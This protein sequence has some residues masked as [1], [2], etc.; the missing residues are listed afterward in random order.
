VPPAVADPL[1]PPPVFAPLGRSITLDDVAVVAVVLEHLASVPVLRSGV[2]GTARVRLLAE[3]APSAQRLA[4]ALVE[5][6][7]LHGCAARRACTVAPR[8]RRYA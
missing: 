5:H 7:H 8:G 2:V 6:L 3:G 4:A 1:P